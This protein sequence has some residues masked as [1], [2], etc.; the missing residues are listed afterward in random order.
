MKKLLTLGTLALSFGAQAMTVPSGTLVCGNSFY[1]DKAYNDLVNGNELTLKE[2]VSKKQC[3][4]I[5][6]DMNGV[7]VERSGAVIKGKFSAGGDVVTVYFS[8]AEVLFR[9]NE[10]KA[11]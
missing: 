6:R 7:E 5:V 4:F 2:L 8:A 3:G 9:K 10:V 11:H 1:L